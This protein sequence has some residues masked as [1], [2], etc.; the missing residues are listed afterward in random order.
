MPS[1]YCVY[2]QSAY[3]SK[4]ALFVHVYFDQFIGP[5]RAT[6]R[7]ANATRGRTCVGFGIICAG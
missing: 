6:K 5:R 1:W 4:F 3:S 2:V 7:S